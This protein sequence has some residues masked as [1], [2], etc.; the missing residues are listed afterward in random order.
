MASAL[1]QIEIIDLKISEALNKSVRDRGSA[2]QDILKVLRDFDEAV[3]VLIVSGDPDVEYDYKEVKPA[4]Y[5]LGQGDD[6]EKKKSLHS[7]AYYNRA[8]H[9]TPWT[10]VPQ[11]G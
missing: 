6:D 9:T 11:S 4:F 2:A 7:I 8:R 10:K 5:K 1:R 3:A